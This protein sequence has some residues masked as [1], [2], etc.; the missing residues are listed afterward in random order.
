MTYVI[1]EPCVGVKDASCVEI[2]PVDAIHPRQDEAGFAQAEQLF[3]DPGACIDCGCCE[4]ECPVGA[5]YPED[6]VPLE[7]L[8]Y[9]A[10]NADFFK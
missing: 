10:R 5:I 6:D 1:T 7:W 8:H 4:P 9:V 3:I 2:C